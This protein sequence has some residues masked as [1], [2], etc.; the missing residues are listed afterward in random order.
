MMRLLASRILMKKER[1]HHEVLI[2]VFN[3]DED[4]EDFSQMLRNVNESIV[5]PWERLADQA[6]V[7]EL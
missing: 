3:D 5:E 2:R 7:I 4:I 6:F 1:I